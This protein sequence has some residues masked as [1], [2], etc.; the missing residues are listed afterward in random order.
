VGLFN[1]FPSK[2]EPDLSVVI[3]KATELGRTQGF[4]EGVVAA[5]EAYVAGIDEGLK[6][7]GE[8]HPVRPFLQEMRRSA[9]ETAA[10]V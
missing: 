7:V 5:L 2:P 1:R 10:R 4:R 3:E 6:C 8:D 9:K